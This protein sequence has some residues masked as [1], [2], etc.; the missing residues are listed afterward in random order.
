[1]SSIWGKIL[2]GA[3]GF[4]LGG[5][6]G[7]LIGG[8]AGHVYDTKRASE[9]EAESGAAT[10]FDRAPGPDPTRQIGF[11]IAVIA[12]GAKLAKADG[13]VTRDEVAAFREVFKVPPDEVRN[14]ARVFDLAKKSPA[15]YRSYARQ[16]AGMFADNP[17]VL[18][19]LLDCL[20]HIARADGRLSD[21]E[22]AY[23]ADVAAIFGF[24]ES[25]Y[26]RIRAENVGPDAADPY[27]VLGVAHDAGDDEVRRAWRAL[28]RENHPDRLIAQGMP[29]EFVSIANDKLAAINA[30]WDRIAAWRGLN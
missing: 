30:A 20:F 7:A 25:D 14:V 11:T 12:L 3:A 1:M 24:S 17:A 19:E 8:I 9:L 27:Q 18:E 10:G 28:V 22:D 29:E 5:P 2:G 21:E 15:G 23:I 16:V 26:A 13:R 6:L 4:A